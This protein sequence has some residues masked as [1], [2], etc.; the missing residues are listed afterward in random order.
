L[1]VFL[2]SWPEIEKAG[3]IFQF[4]GNFFKSG[5]EIVNFRLAFSISG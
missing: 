3:W 5:T 2:Q 1:S 4:P